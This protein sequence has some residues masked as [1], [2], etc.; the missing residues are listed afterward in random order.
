[1]AKDALDR[2]GFIRLG[3]AAGTLLPVVGS[4]LGPRAGRAAGHE[5]G[6]EKL[7]TDLEANA[8]MVSAFQYVNESP[9][10]AEGQVCTTCQLYTAK[11]DKVGKCQ[12]FQTGVVAADGWCLS[13]AKK[14]S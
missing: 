13:W 5:G 11:D 1:M 7:V 2:R 4:T 12:F 10:K 3:L 6:E 8:P 9:K 14:V